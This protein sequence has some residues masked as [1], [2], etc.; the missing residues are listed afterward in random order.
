MPP[1][2]TAGRYFPDL[3]SF[4]KAWP[5]ASQA[6]DAL[7]AARV[8]GGNATAR[9]LTLFVPGNRAF[10]QAG[11]DVPRLLVSRD[12]A[13]IDDV[14]R[15]AGMARAVRARMPWCEGRGARAP[16]ACGCAHSTPYRPLHGRPPM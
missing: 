3:V 2:T 1:A 9:P 7:R 4:C 8:L 11:L 16:I 5:Q 6:C 10:G 15:C 14:I 12:V 13:R